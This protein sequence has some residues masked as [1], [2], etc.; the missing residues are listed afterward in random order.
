MK[1]L[2][3]LALVTLVSLPLLAADERPRRGDDGAN[4]QFDL[5]LADRNAGGGRSERSVQALALD[6]S[7]IRLSTGWRIPIPTTTFN[8]AN[9]VGSDIVPVTS[10]QYQDV[11]VSASFENRIVGGNRIRI[12]G[13]IEVSAI[14]Q[15]DD[16]ASEA[17][18][19]RVGAFSHEFDVI[20][21]DGVETTLA[22]VPKPD[23]G[24]MTLALSAAIRN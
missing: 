7:R 4:V 13:Q 19:P 22:E 18:G 11:G 8:T 16:A 6:G 10:Y 15:G 9:T 1:K 20:L 23:G 14:D 5:T 24:T 3:A 2:I 17:A 12:A 21:V